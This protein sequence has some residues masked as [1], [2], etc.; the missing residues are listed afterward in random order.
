[1][2]FVAWGT[3]RR[4]VACVCAI[5]FITERDALCISI[6]IIFWQLVILEVQLLCAS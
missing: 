3:E 1:M 6:G 2:N 5:R 4:S